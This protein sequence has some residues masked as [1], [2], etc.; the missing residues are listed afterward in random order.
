MLTKLILNELKKISN[1]NNEQLKFF[2][3]PL[4]GGRNC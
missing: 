1:M 2:V 3:L 4:Q